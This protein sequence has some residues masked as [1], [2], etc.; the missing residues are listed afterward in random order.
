VLNVIKIVIIVMEQLILIVLNVL[1][2]TIEQYQELLV[3]VIQHIK[4]LEIIKHAIVLLY[5]NI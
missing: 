1:Q 2:V 3:H 5:F 4:M